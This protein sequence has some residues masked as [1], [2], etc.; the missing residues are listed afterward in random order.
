MNFKKYLVIGL[1]SLVSTNVLAQRCESVQVE[2]V[3][4]GSQFNTL[5]RTVD[6]SCGSNGFICLEPIGDLTQTAS[7]QIYAAALTSQASGADVT[8]AWNLG[9]RGC[10]NNFPVVTEFR[11]LNPAQ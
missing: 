8:V 5:I 2:D 4:S 6:R 9:N 10:G 11:V 1:L 7:N 3:I